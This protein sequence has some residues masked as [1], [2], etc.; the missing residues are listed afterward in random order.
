MSQ[1]SFGNLPDGRPARLYTL[2]NR[3]V[4]VRITNFG[5]RIVSI[6]CADQWNRQGEVLLGFTDAH[7][8]AVAGGAFGALVGRYAKRIAN[9]SL[10]INGHSY[11]L[12]KNDRGSTLH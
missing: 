8:Y 4:R 1:L 6:G 3:D 7:A 5:G 2:E 12:A 10:L 11:H 9:G